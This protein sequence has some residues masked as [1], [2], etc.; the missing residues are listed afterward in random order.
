MTAGVIDRLDFATAFS[1]ALLARHRETRDR[2]RNVAGRIDANR[3]YWVN[4]IRGIRGFGVAR[5]N[6]C[7][8]LSSYS[9]REEVR[10]RIDQDFQ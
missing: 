5:R 1:N 10:E 8:R 4:R 3:G 2:E 7:R 9:L 6:E